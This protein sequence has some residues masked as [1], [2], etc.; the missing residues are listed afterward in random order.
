MSKEKEYRTY[1]SRLDNARKDIS[2]TNRGLNNLRIAENFYA[3]KKSMRL[4]MDNTNYNN[5]SI[6]NPKSID[7]LFNTEREF[8]ETK[9][10]TLKVELNNL[11]LQL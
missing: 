3:E 10:I 9:L 2:D 7:A 4:S 6:Q 11:E 8:L 1:L 5:Y